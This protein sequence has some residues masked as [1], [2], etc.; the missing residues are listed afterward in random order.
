MGENANSANAQSLSTTLGKML[1]INP[2]GTIPSDNPFFSQDHRASTRR[3]GRW[4]C[5][6]RS[7]SPSIR[8][9]GRMFI[10]DVGESTWEEVNHGVAGSNYG[11]PQTEGR[12]PAAESR[13]FATR[14]TP[15]R[16][17]ASTCAIAGGAFYRPTSGTFPAEYAGRYFF[18]DF[19]AGFIRMLS[20]PN[21]SGATRF[22]QRHR[23]AWSTSRWHRTAALYYL[24]RGGGEVFRVQFTGNTAPSISTQP[25][26]HHGVR[27]PVRELLR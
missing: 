10:N 17:T 22:R 16:T 15:T 20:P 11:W 12:Q 2:D 6:T 24:A 26:N 7:P 3:S 23:L 18:G 8:T 13:A 14:S 1:R 19:C 4:A 25:P 27:R 9:N 21:Y 5:A